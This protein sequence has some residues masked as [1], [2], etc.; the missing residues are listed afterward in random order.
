MTRA[1]RKKIM[2]LSGLAA[3]TITVPQVISLPIYFTK[4][5][6]DTVNIDVSFRSPNSSII[7]NALGIDNSKAS[8]ADNNLEIIK[9]TDPVIP[10]V[11]PKEEI[12]PAPPVEEPIVTTPITP[13]VPVVPEK[14]ESPLTPGVDKTNSQG[15]GSSI[16]SVD[17]VVKINLPGGESMNVPVKV[18]HKL[19]DPRHKFGE[20]DNDIINRVPYINNDA[21][22]IV[23]IEVTDEIKKAVSKPVRDHLK[24]MLVERG[25]DSWRNY[26][27][28]PL[29]DIDWD[30]IELSDNAL[31]M[32]AKG[33]V[34]DYTNAKIDE[35]GKLD[36]FSYSPLNDGYNGVTG[37]M[38]RDNKNRRLFGYNSWYVRSPKDIEE[39]NFTGWNKEDVK[40][41][42]KVF[43]LE[44]DDGIQVYK[45]TNPDPDP[46]YQKG[47]NAIKVI[48][49]AENVKGYGKFLSFLEKYQKA[50][51]TI[52]SFVIRN[53]GSE[54]T[55]SSQKF[56]EIL[57]K[58]PNKI[59]QLE[60]WFESN[61]TS[62]LI[63]LRGKEIDELAF[64]TKGNSLVD[65]WVLNPWA[66][67]KAAY[68]QTVDYNVSFD[69]GP[70]VKPATRITFNTLGFDP[71]NYKPG[72][73][74][75]FH[76]MNKGLRMAY[77]VRNNEPIF[78]GGF[79]PGLNPDNHEAG[80]SYPS[81]LDLSRIS[82]LKS[83]KGLDF[84]GRKL[85]R[86]VLY[87]DTPAFK[88]PIEEMEVSKFFTVMH[89]DEPEDPNEKRLKFNGAVVTKLHLTGTKGLSSTGMQNL[90]TFY[91]E[92]GKK[93]FNKPGG[94]I[95]VDKGNTTL[96]N[97]LKTAGYPVDY[98][99]PDDDLIFN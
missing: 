17:T 38:T 1:K 70:S 47:N 22:E 73:A 28:K 30:K 92:I 86:L 71:E 33:M 57:S 80:N 90:E 58:L 77:L 67:D 32:L 60:L 85:R 83:L 21:P 66:I 15:E 44:D 43:G 87:S 72:D 45:Y 23:E 37:R 94:K 18:K 53:M 62:S 46:S 11:P 79:G 84:L 9:P 48:L 93:I 5:N 14:P 55:G 40:A 78:Q 10:V 6:N 16:V 34:I 4:L 65:E 99:N 95:I 81:G 12:K 98:A 82:S 51:K 42:W 50:G 69:Y 96:Y 76:D 35:N 29:S 27:G 63:A 64:Y 56:K 13:E 91:R 54:K 20:E 59:P 19:A 68:I 89:L 7:N 25:L 8:N 97:Q 75:P 74:D 3:I 2:L 49:D 31:A 88:M 61:N 41:D 39:G 52:H 26:S 36:S 24:Y